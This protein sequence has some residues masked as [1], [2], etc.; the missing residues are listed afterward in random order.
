MPAAKQAA[1]TK[2]RLEAQRAAWCTHRSL[3]IQ[4]HVSKTERKMLWRLPRGLRHVSGLRV[5]LDQGYTLLD[6][7]CRTQTALDKLAKLRRRLLRFPQV[8]A[9]LKKLLAPTVAKVL[10]FLD[11]KLLPAT[12]KAVE[13]G[14]RRD[15]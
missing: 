6:R 14:N 9:T 15:R 11:D 3:G 2:K 8:G 1:R 4:R 13:R 12:S 10:T 7:R 5:L